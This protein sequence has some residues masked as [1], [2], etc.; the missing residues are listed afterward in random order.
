MHG[1]SWQSYPGC[2][3]FI[4]YMHSQLHNHCPCFTDTLL[5][6][7][8]LQNFHPTH[9]WSSPGSTTSQLRSS[10]LLHKTPFFHS[11]SLSFFHSLSLYC[12]I[13]CNIPCFTHSAKSPVIPAHT[14]SFF[15]SSICMTPYIHSILFCCSFNPSFSL[16]LC[17]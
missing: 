14:F 12:P 8:S 10:Y 4:T 15:T 1:I 7:N 5:S 13:H 2:I 9:S 17:Y 11:L 6:I 16:M 3:T